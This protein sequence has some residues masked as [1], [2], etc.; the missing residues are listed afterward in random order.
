MN[1]YSPDDVA[2]WNGFF[3][4]TIRNVGYDPSQINNLVRVL[5]LSPELTNIRPVLIDRIKKSLLFPGISRL[6][7]LDLRIEVEYGDGPRRFY[8]AP[9]RVAAYSA[10][11]HY[12]LELS[13]QTNLR[14][15]NIRNYE[16]NQFF[17]RFG[18]AVILDGTGGKSIELIVEQNKPQSD[19]EREMATRAL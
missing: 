11:V 6:E 12:F 4:N 16:T 15:V 5:Q 19:S 8:E 2:I 18:G 1:T 10:A 13:S 7:G 3:Q 9:D 17:A 14:I